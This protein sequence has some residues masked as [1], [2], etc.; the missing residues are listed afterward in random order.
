MWSSVEETS[1]RSRKYSVWSTL[2]IKFSPASGWLLLLGC[3]L[4]LCCLEPNS[5]TFQTFLT[6]QPKIWGCY[7]LFLNFIYCLWRKGGYICSFLQTH[8]YSIIILPESIHLIIY[9]IYHRNESICNH[10]F[11]LFSHGSE[12]EQV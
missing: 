3:W 6:L 7:W 2:I 12:L 11:N 9:T 8:E 1:L 10:N 5:C 4:L